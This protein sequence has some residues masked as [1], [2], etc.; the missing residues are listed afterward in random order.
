MIERAQT[1]RFDDGSKPRHHEGRQEQTHPEPAWILDERTRENQKSAQHVK[2]TVGQIQDA[3]HAQEN[4]EARGDQEENHRVGQPVQKLGQPK[5]DVQFHT[6]GPPEKGEAT[7]REI[8]G[9]S[10]ASRVMIISGSP[11][12][13][14]R[15]GENPRREISPECSRESGKDISC[16]L[17]SRPR[18][19]T[20][21]LGDRMGA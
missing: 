4:R 21:T 11:G 8:S 2:R 9:A 7:P 15:P 19:W 14:S 16:F 13:C 3:Q 20:A 12:P 18:S 17:K 6:P 1:K 10:V 5:T